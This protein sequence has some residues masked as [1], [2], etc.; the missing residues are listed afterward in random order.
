MLGFSLLLLVWEASAAGFGSPEGIGTVLHDDGMMPGGLDS[1]QYTAKLLE[2]ID[3]L[4]KQNAALR[5]YQQ[6]V[7]ETVVA[8]EI[9]EGVDTTEDGQMMGTVQDVKEEAARE[10]Q[11]ESTMVGATEGVG[12]RVYHFAASDDVLGLTVYPE[13]TTHSS[14]GVC[15]DEVDEALKKTCEKEETQGGS[16]AFCCL[17]E[18]KRLVAAESARSNGAAMALTK[19][20]CMRIK[21]EPL[22][23]G[24]GTQDLKDAFATAASQTCTGFVTVLEL[25]DGKD[26]ADLLNNW[27]YYADDG[28]LH[29]GGDTAEFSAIVVTAQSEDGVATCEKLRPTYSHLKIVCALEG[30]RES[31]YQQARWEVYMSLVAV[32]LDIPVLVTKVQHL[33]FKPIAPYL[34]RNGIT[35]SYEQ[36]S[37]II[38]FGGNFLFGN[39]WGGAAYF[40]DIVEAW[41]EGSG[42]SMNS[43]W[44]TWAKNKKSPEYFVHNMAAPPDA[45]GPVTSSGGDPYAGTGSEGGDPQQFLRHDVVTWDGVSIGNM[46]RFKAWYPQPVLKQTLPALQTLD[47][48][49]DA[50]NPPSKLHCRAI[51]VTKSIYDTDPAYSDLAEKLDLAAKKSCT[52]YVTMTILTGNF[53]CYLDN[54][55][56]FLSHI[57]VGQS[58]QR[59]SPIVAVCADRL[60]VTNCEKLVETFPGLDVYC[61]KP[62]FFSEEP[63]KKATNAGGGNAAYNRLMWGKPDVLKVAVFKGIPVFWNDL[64]VINFKDAGPYFIWDGRTVQANCEATQADR[65]NAGVLFVGGRFVGNGLW[66]ASPMKHFMQVWNSTYHWTN[67]GAV[68]FWQNEQGSLERMAVAYRGSKFDEAHPSYYA[69]LDANYNFRSLTLSV[70]R[71]Q[72]PVGIPRSP[73]SMAQLATFHVVQANG[74]K[75]QWMLDHECWRPTV[76]KEDGKHCTFKYTN[77]EVVPVPD[78]FVFPPFAD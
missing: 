30:A 19:F 33:Q 38:F 23:D 42:R 14:H 37:G 47:L 71:M 64:D 69:S 70:F 39:Y 54:W 4:Q 35:I 5:A 56:T 46:K 48:P 28:E 45:K 21:S 49:A 43:L 26:Q 57:P 41:H 17:S 12:A 65:P 8:Q 68:K 36:S 40:K 62:A 13:K 72:Q 16:G 29:H 51:K 53:A 15:F 78:G 77:D 67:D 6:V 27:L 22:E 11:A 34:V 52:G 18:T 58:G 31:K 7:Q 61:A 2:T 20:G 76:F 66:D 3:T 9:K 55:L 60:G 73:E 25:K 32:N 24:P 1:E 74:A 44:S 50:N 10:A 75:Q 59:S 63:I